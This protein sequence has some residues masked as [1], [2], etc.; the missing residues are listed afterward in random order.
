[1]NDVELLYIKFID[2]KSFLYGL[3]INFSQDFRISCKDNKK[4]EI[5]KIENHNIFD[6]NIE[7]FNVLIGKNGCGK[8]TILNTIFKVL[9]GKIG[10]E[11]TKEKII[12]L[13]KYTSDNEYYIYIFCFDDIECVPN[14]S[15]PEEKIKKVKDDF[16]IDIIPLNQRDEDYIQQTYNRIYISDFMDYSI[17]SSSLKLEENYA[18]NY[19][20]AY[21][22]ANPNEFLNMGRNKSII[23]TMNA[24]KLINRIHEIN[25][26]DKND[27]IKFLEDDIKK[28]DLIKISFLNIVIDFENLCEGRYGK[29]KYEDE[30]KICNNLKGMNIK[31]INILWYLYLF[32]AV[33]CILDLSKYPQYEEKLL[34]NKEYKDLSGEETR[35]FISKHKEMFWKKTEE[36]RTE[37]IIGKKS[38]DDLEKEIQSA[39]TQCKIEK[40]YCEIE[41]EGEEDYFL[42]EKKIESVFSNYREIKK[43]YEQSN[44]NG[45][46]SLS[47]SKAHEFLGK[48]L[49]L[50]NRIDNPV[51][52][53]CDKSI[54]SE[55]SYL[56]NNKVFYYSSGESA[57]IRYYTYIKLGVDRIK[58]INKDEILFNHLLNKKTN[59]LINLLLDE[60]TNS[61][62][63][64]MQKHFIKSLTDYLK[65]FEDCRFNVLITTHSP[66]ITSELTRNHVIYLKREKDNKVI[67]LTDDEKPKSFAQ[68]IYSLYREN[69]YVQKGLIGTFADNILMNIYEQINANNKKLENSS[70]ISLYSEENIKYI[71]YEI[72]EPIIRDKFIRCL[73]NN[74]LKII[75]EI[76][77]SQ[78]IDSETKQNLIEL[79]IKNRK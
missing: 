72:G 53:L 38:I 50:V 51:Y 25:F 30:K 20:P 36:I 41:A 24:F 19:S 43:I 35:D 70:Y 71:I 2:E 16:F 31:N 42:I 26:I 7:N 55:I 3:E 1:M 32:S 49:L 63:P 59:I 56:K 46:I 52:Y 57:L 13:K 17:D 5:K 77:N 15:I 66:I 11:E 75:N 68:N 44:G 4:I 54:P 18:L 29:G 67:S 69:F 28:P 79:I 39:I 73:N 62:H 74:T 9:D 60:P 22:I 58:E 23:P 45:T 10:N 65:T 8:T 64:D 37:F 47:L 12:V 27:N 6:G 78:E 33:M 14:E 76:R 40:F 34:K 21:L 48:Y 61:M